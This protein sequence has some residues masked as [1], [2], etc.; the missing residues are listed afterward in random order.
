MRTASFVFAACGAAMLPI[1]AFCDD[2]TAALRAGG[3]EFTKA[4]QIRMVVQDLRISPNA[5]A[6]RYE[7]IN[8]GDKDVD[9]LVAFPLPDIDTWEF[10]ESPIGETTNDPVNFVGFKASA[11]G[12]PV[13]VQVEQR[14]IYHGRDVTGLVQSAGVPV[15][16][17]LNQNFHK[18]DDLPADK[19]KMLERAGIAEADAPDQEHPKWIVRTR[20]YWTQHFPAH[21]T[22]VL[23]QSYK[24]VTGQAFFSD[25]EWG[26]KAGS[27]DDRWKK[28]YCMDD[29]T[30]AKV[31]T[32]VAAAKQ[33]PDR[34]SGMLEAYS[35]DFILKT[36][37]N[38]KGG[39][40]NFHL[41]IDKLKPG[42][43]LSLCWAGALRKTGPTTFEF[44]AQNFRPSADL[45]F[46]VLE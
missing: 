35:T 8:D 44:A 23:E 28:A 19:K 36:A 43:T 38:W 29:A 26:E 6:I 13:P 3:I 17:I 30:I 12:K 11:D 25:T 7:F 39:A 32:M 1:T 21:K 24:P 37:N 22:V 42:N 9:A 16:V 4:P 10:Y 20:F 18:L 33:H 31:K 2:S 34:N 41:T 15:N 46:V 45:A 27:A 14:A 40:G 5:V